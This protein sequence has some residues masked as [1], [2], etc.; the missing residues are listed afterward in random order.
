MNLAGLRH[1][2]VHL[3]GA[4]PHPLPEMGA[5]TDAVD[6]ALAIGLV[7]A[8]LEEWATWRPGFEPMP[9]PTV[10]HQPDAADLRMAAQCPQLA[11]L[12]EKHLVYA[13]G[14]VEA[15][16]ADLL[17]QYQAAGVADESIEAALVD[18]RERLAA[19]TADGA[20]IPRWCAK[21]LSQIA[22]DNPAGS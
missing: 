6:L 12:A 9:E 5:T 21:F 4:V 10:L 8:R 11:D 3:A 14:V 1:R 2:L 17:S 18:V 20:P 15:R 7:H 19:L 16:L 13:P 22:T